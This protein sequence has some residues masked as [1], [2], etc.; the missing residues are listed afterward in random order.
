MPVSFLSP[1]RCQRYGRCDGN[2]T[3]AQLARYFRLDDADRSLYSRVRI[4]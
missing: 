3:A 1:L 2:P 4:G